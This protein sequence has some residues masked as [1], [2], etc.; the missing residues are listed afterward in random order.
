MY[1]DLTKALVE[2]WPAAAEDVVN[3]SEAALALSPD[4]F[5]QP[6]L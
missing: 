2:E 3:F 6:T 4:S 1:S 5:R